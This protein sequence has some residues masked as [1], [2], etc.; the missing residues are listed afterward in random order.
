MLEETE[1]L[2]SIYEKLIIHDKE[3]KEVVISVAKY[4]Y[5]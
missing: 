5:E 4:K 2:Q 3:V 1:N